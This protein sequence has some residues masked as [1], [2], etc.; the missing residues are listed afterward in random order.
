MK[1]KRVCHSRLS[2]LVCLMCVCETILK[3][4]LEK[5]CDRRRKKEKK[6]WWKNGWSGIR[7]VCVCSFIND[8]ERHKRVIYIEIHF[9]EEKKT[10][11][12]AA[13]IYI[14]FVFKPDYYVR[15]HDNFQYCPMSM[16]QCRLLEKV[17]RSIWYTN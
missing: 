17:L 12:L 7:C 4:K 1:K 5:L 16:W 13:N 6:I 8:D 15:L 14:S 11:G 3:F 10:L 9:V 2:A